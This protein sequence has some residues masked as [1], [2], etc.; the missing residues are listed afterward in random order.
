MVGHLLPKQ[1]NAGSIP[2]VRSNSC[3]WGKN[4]KRNGIF[5]K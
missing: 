1:V 3:D 4:E 2:V 5:K